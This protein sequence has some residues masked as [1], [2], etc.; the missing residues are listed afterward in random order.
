VP[1][2]RLRAQ[3]QRAHR[4]FASFAT[5]SDGFGSV[6]FANCCGRG[7]TSAIN[8]DRSCLCIR[9]FPR[10]MLVHRL[11]WRTWGVQ[12]F[13]GKIRKSGQSDDVGFLRSFPNVMQPATSRSSVDELIVGVVCIRGSPWWLLAAF[14]CSVLRFIFVV[15]CCFGVLDW[16][17]EGAR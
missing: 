1:V 13:S 4:K 2:W 7:R 6:Y 3:H 5:N 17:L 10:V 14:F 12:F 15:V 9:T 16:R 11:G 8:F